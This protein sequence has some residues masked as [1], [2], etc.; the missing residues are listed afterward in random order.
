MIENADNISNAIKNTDWYTTSASLDKYIS[1]LENAIKN[2]DLYTVSPDLQPCKNEY[3]LGLIDDYNAIIS[4]K[5]GINLM[6]NG[7]FKS[8]TETLNQGTNNLRLANS[9]YDN[10]TKLLKIYNTAYP[11]KS[12]EIPVIQHN[13]APE[14]TQQ[15]TVSTPIETPTP[16]KVK[17][18]ADKDTEPEGIHTSGEPV[19]NVDTSENTK[20]VDSSTHNIFDY[21]TWQAQITKKIGEYFKAPE[22]KNYV[23]VTI[24]INNTG[25]KTY[26]TNPGYWHLKIGD[27]Y[28]QHDSTTYDSSLNHMTTD[29]GPGGKIITKMAYIVDGEPSISDLELYYDG[30]GSDGTIYS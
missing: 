3:K 21:C 14:V 1:D 12:L 13:V 24:K 11:D 6:T 9:H 7:D 17:T 5:A 29:V 8:S 23:V 20:S 30:P 27:M 10:V 4:M 18:L 25:D 26:S 15:S 2:S 22:N 28:Y 16:D 19:N